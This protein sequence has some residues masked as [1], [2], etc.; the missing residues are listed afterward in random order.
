MTASVGLITGIATQ[1]LWDA[2][3][4]FL[5]PTVS[6]TCA[7]LLT[8]VICEDRRPPIELA[9]RRSW[10]LVVGLLIGAVAM[11]TVLAL[12]AIFG[13]VTIHR[14]ASVEW[15]RWWLLVGSSVVGAGIA[16]EI[17][18][19]GV[20]FRFLENLAGTWGAVA[21]SGLIF[22]L[23]HLP[24]ANATLWSAIAI[25]L[26]AG[27]FFGLFY[28]LFRSLWL[29]IGVHAAWNATLGAVL[30]TPV[31]GIESYGLF[32]TTL[33]GSDAVT[34]G[35]FGVEASVLTVVVF[36]VIS[37]WLAARLARSGRAFAPAWRKS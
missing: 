32:T 10:H 14:S 6:T 21:V 36:L 19:R 35:A 20:L 7:Y 30:G 12:I 24:N 16:E 34:G 22:G 26:T 15:N 9:P 33:S 37:S 31:S 27:V 13:E 11:L 25:A 3:Q 1:F 17:L 28:A 29:V 18:M 23:L 8:C 4:Q 2:I 5:V